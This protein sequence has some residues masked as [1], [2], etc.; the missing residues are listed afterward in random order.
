[1]SNN[2]DNRWKDIYSLETED[3]PWR[4]FL[5]TL[6]QDSSGNVTFT[7][8]KHIIGLKQQ[9]IFHALAEE[10]MPKDDANSPI[11]PSS[12]H[13][14]EARFSIYATSKK[15]MGTYLGM[16]CI[17]PGNE[18]YCFNPTENFSELS[19]EEFKQEL[20]QSLFSFFAN[21]AW[22]EKPFIQ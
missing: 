18:C 17:D 8:S 3:S 6:Y 13:M 5:G 19:P 2:L 22:I 1:M 12:F 14:E 4:Q 10:F 11:L 15:N 9:Q 16:L 20:N 21:F 7:P